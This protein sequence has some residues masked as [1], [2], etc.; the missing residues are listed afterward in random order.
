MTSLYDVCPSFSQKIL[1]SPEHVSAAAFKPLQLKVKK[2]NTNK[3]QKKEIK[4]EQQIYYK[5]KEQ[6]IKFT[7]IS[8]R[9]TRVIKRIALYSGTKVKN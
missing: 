3:K 8:Y 6:K 9:N 1:N 2:R 4:I 7:N 5:K